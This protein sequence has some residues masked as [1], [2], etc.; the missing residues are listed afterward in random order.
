MNKR[1]SSWLLK[2]IYLENMNVD[3]LSLYFIPLTCYKLLNDLQ[4]FQMY[5]IHFKLLYN[6]IP[7]TPA[8]YVTDSKEAS[9]W[10]FG[11]YLKKFFL[12]LSHP[13]I[14]TLTKTFL[15]LICLLIHFDCCSHMC[16]SKLK[17]SKLTSLKVKVHLLPRYEHQCSY[18][19]YALSSIIMNSCHGVSK[20]QV[21]QLIRRE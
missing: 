10:H 14:K 1:S 12:N 11:N 4:S 6:F 8:H 5:N 16:P 2:Y 3:C 21:L 15:F 20:I 18:V 13:C 17:A 19:N 9:E 7:R